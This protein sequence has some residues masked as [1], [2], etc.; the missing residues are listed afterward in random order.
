MS[1]LLNH[2]INRTKSFTFA[3]YFRVYIFYFKKSARHPQCEV[4]SSTNSSQSS[5]PFN[6]LASAHFSL[7]CRN[8]FVR[9]L[10]CLVLHVLCKSRRKK[11]KSFVSG[12]LTFLCATLKACLVK[13]SF[14]AAADVRFVLEHYEELVW[15]QVSAKRWKWEAVLINWPW[16]GL[17]PAWQVWSYHAP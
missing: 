15:H 5:N 13:S 10:R 3:Q 16:M 14:T 4:V 1:R 11:G 2:H 8:D 12:C 7:K 6:Y 17:G 9:L